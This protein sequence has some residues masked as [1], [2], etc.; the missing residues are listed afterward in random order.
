M[1]KLVFSLVLGFVLISAVHSESRYNNQSGISIYKNY[2]KIASG[3]KL[4]DDIFVTKDSILNYNNFYL[5]KNNDIFYN[6]EVIYVDRVSGLAFLKIDIPG[7][8]EI[9]YDQIELNENDP[10]YIY[11]NNKYHKIGKYVK[12]IKGYGLLNTDYKKLYVAMPLYNK[13]KKFIGLLLGYFQKSHYLFLRNNILT[14][15]QNNINSVLN[16]GKPNL[17]IIVSE[18]W[19]KN[20]IKV[21][22]SMNNKFKKGD[23]IVKIE[24]KNI[25][26]VLDFNISLYEYNEKPSIEFFIRRNNGLI[27]IRIEGGSNEEK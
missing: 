18:M 5:K 1:K 21:I 12:K 25:N 23:V 15:Y 27:S 19:H 22:K 24:D 6:Y 7:D 3:I 16:H 10:I 2:K 20:G 4:T 13:N 11:E 17:N 9:F 26:N 14:F 8:K